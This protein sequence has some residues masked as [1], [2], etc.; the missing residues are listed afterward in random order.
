[1]NIFVLKIGENSGY[2]LNSGQNS[3]FGYEMKRNKIFA[4]YQ[5]NMKE[6]A[7]LE[8]TKCTIIYFN[9]DVMD[10]SCIFNKGIFHLF[11][12]LLQLYNIKIYY[13]KNN[14]VI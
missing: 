6:N 12:I 14:I 11:C 13:N 5:F 9:V 4:E 8:C 7:L 1:M 2:K 10:L 3:L